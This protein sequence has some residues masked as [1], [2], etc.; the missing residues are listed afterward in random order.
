MQTPDLKNN[1]QENQ[2]DGQVQGVDLQTQISELASHLTETEA[3]FDNFKDSLDPVRLQTSKDKIRS[4][5]AK[6]I[7][8]A[9]VEIK[10]Q[11][12]KEQL[13]QR[14]QQIG[15]EAAGGV[16]PDL[17]SSA[18]ALELGIVQAKEKLLQTDTPGISDL[19]EYYTQL[20]LLI[21]Q[22]EAGQAAGSDASEGAID[23]GE[24]TND[25]L[26]D[27][28][29]V[30]GEPRE[31]DG[32]LMADA[33]AKGSIAIHI[34]SPSEAS[35]RYEGEL[36]EYYDDRRIQKTNFSKTTD[37]AFDKF[38]GSSSN[39]SKYASVPFEDVLRE[40]NVH[41][42]V[43]INNFDNK[44]TAELVL[45]GDDSKPVELIY[46]ALSNNTDNAEFPSKIQIS[47][48]LPEKVGDQIAQRAR[49][50]PVFFQRLL[51][52]MIASRPSGFQLGEWKKLQG[53]MSKNLTS[54]NGHRRL[55]VTNM[56]ESFNPT[57]LQQQGV[58]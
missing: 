58:S 46:T 8:K 53:E 50:Y 12:E 14:D 15:S 18:S 54:P 23:D 10:Q 33:V 43:G 25:E 21:K 19:L 6:L 34:S 55:M 32:E 4:I 26:E 30:Q 16:K 51:D 38:V 49:E 41:E 9:G 37:R 52:R 2:A 36:R 5:A 3:F 17:K 48:I 20:D 7:E 44:K 35:R 1:S 40:N 29:Y 47:V 39:D 24:I 27:D 13:R 31:E 28:E 22:A 11:I 42:I 45:A 57:A 56:A